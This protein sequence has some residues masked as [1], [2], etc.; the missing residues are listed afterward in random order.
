M[1]PPAG[2]VKFSDEQIVTSGLVL[3]LDA[4]YLRSYTGSG[5]T[6]YDASGRGNNGTLMNEPTYSSADG[7]SI[8]FD[9]SNDHVEV[10][11]SNGFGEANTTPTMTLDLWANVVRKD[12]GGVQYQQLAG[13]RDET[14]FDFYFLLLDNSGTSV[15]TEARVR[16]TSGAFN[17]GV[18]YLS[19][20]G[21]WTHI[22]FVAN[23]TR[24]DLYFNG[25]LVGSNTN[26][27]GTFGPT[28]GNFRIGLNTDGT[29]GASGNI[30]AVK[31]YNRAL[32]ASEIQ[33]NFNA[34]RSRFGI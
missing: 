22:C 6:W 29:W 30:S 31:V 12:G 20:F 2:F 7:G 33:Q 11:T 3:N 13:F 18:P 8:V 24:I 25:I 17:I 5:T 34:T 26:V 27:S 1:T 21:K 28:S 19:Y 4:G 15:S 10:S 16:T 32:T 14:N 23:A 9:G